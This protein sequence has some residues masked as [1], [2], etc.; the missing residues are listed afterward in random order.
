M[1]PRSRP[2]RNA[3]RARR[4]WLLQSLELGDAS[5]E[6]VEFG[7]MDEHRHRLIAAEDDVGAVV[8]A[9]DEFLGGV[10]EVRDAYEPVHTGKCNVRP[11][12]SQDIPLDVRLGVWLNDCMRSHP[13]H[14]MQIVTGSAAL[15]VFYVV[16]HAL[17][18]L[19]QAM[20]AAGAA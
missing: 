1:P 9:V 8:E 17:V 10:A 12:V 7:G 18:V 5:E 16:L 6:L 11:N 2:E 20:Q 15:L 13:N 14:L 3:G 19:N 4:R